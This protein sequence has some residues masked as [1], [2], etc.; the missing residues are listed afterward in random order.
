VDDGYSPQNSNEADAIDE[1]F[2]AVNK[3]FASCAGAGKP[4]RYKVG[5]YGPGAVCEWLKANGR[6]EY[7][8][9]S[10]AP[11][12]PGADYDGWNIKQGPKDD[13]LAVDNDTDESSSGDPGFWNLAKSPESEG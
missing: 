9:L 5:V 7:T 1:Y 12:W 8:W 13:M 10:N 3:A 11:A 6:V 2:Q 4:V